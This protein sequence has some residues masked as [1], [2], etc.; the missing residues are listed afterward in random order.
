MNKEVIIEYL[1]TFLI[2]IFAVFIAVVIF[3]AVIQNQV[4]NDL[5]KK[6]LQD[7]TIDYYLVGV[8]IEKN[9]YLKSMYP[10]N[11]NIDV[12][13]GI[14]Y[15]IK[16][17]Y[18]NAQSEYMQAISKEPYGEFVAQYRL[19]LLYLK[20]RKLSDAENLMD[21]IE[22]RPDKKLIFYK[23]RLFAKLGD[24][25][26]NS[27]DYED[28]IDK[29][30]HSLSYYKLLN[31]SQTEVVKNS[32]ASSYVYLADQQVK[33]MQIDDARD[34][35]QMAMTM[36]KAPVLK[37][38]MAIL[39][40][41]D[42]PALAYNYF[43][44]VFEKAPEL[45]N[46]QQYNNFLT[47]LAVK[48]E[49]GGDAGLSDLYRYKIKRLEEYYHSNILSVD[50]LSVEYLKGDIKYSNWFK[51]YYATLEFKLKNISSYYI[52]SLFIDIIFKDENDTTID[53]YTN[54]IIDKKPVLKVNDL[55]PVIH[56]KTSKHKAKKA[57]V[58][59]N[60]TVLIYASKTKDGCKILLTQA[61]IKEQP[62]ESRVKSFESYIKE[63]LRKPFEKHH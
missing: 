58:P 28:A 51:N 9:K 38:K 43:D 7:K 26:Y 48:A 19:A 63:F 20:E 14:L 27:A 13:L 55:S 52:S 61:K 47:D 33:A 30:Q 3:L 54:Q 8:L 10:N 12:K 45:I 50:D 37:Y 60:M 41:K 44:E 35:L 29:Y 5:T 56:I 21:N 25:Y 62:I 15:E 24:Q 57:D 2:T 34:S 49:M 4:Y 59:K 17:D 16:K 31:T 42:N 36:V 18:D 11:Y 40:M 46:Y 6:Q 32:L 39:L 22:D 1:R 23:A 53:E